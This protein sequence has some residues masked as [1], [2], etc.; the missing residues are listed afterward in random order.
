MALRAHLDPDI[1]IGRRDLFPLPA[2]IVAALKAAGVTTVNELIPYTE[3]DLLRLRGFEQEDLY[4]VID[5]LE[6]L[7][8]KLDTSPFWL[9]PSRGYGD[10]DDWV[11]REYRRRKS[12][13]SIAARSGYKSP[14]PIVEVLE[15]AGIARRKGTA[16]DRRPDAVTL[17]KMYLADKRTLESIAEQFGVANP[18]V[19]NWLRELGV[20]LRHRG[21]HARR[22]GV[23]TRSFT[24]VSFGYLHLGD[25]PT[26]QADRV[27]D[28]RARLRDPAA[29]RDILDLD[30]R[31]GRVQDVVLATEGAPELLDNLV[32]YAEL[33]GAGPERIAIGC[34]GGKHRAPALVELLA[35]K[36]RDRGHTVVVE[37]IHVHLDRVIHVT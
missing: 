36:L 12:L 24:L 32:E 4:V 9:C 23:A 19:G 13:Q 27:E 22:E 15:R 29:A 2:D 37:H 6:N 28:V 18:T 35:R 14:T 11:V 30:G 7:A 21:R 1:T 25:G 3:D 34:A 10:F 20:E 5:A 31:D 16:Q 33:P 26:P 17:K 8:K